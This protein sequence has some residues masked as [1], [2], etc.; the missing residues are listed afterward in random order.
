MQC[1]GTRNTDGKRCQR[2]PLTGKTKCA[3]HRNQVH[4]YGSAG[5]RRAYGPKEPKAEKQ[6]S[7]KPKAKTT[8]PEQPTKVKAEP[9]PTPAKPKPKPKSKGK[10]TVFFFGG[11]PSSEKT[12]SKSKSK[13][14]PESE[15]KPK[16]KASLEDINSKFD[17]LYIGQLAHGVALEHLSSKTESLLKGHNTLVEYTK[18]TD[19]KTDKVEEALLET[20]QEVKKMKQEL[21]R[22]TQNIYNLYDR[23]DEEPDV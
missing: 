21:N 9:P 13:P 17:N 16:P 20:R 2:A 6:S 18:E 19:H 1:N 23:L 4:D 5:A 14:K 22:A 10:A 3:A 8:P 11:G 7:E 15:P 12:K